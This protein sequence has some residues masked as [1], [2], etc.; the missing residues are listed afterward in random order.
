MLG[1][2][3]NLI[4]LNVLRTLD[5]IRFQRPQTKSRRRETNHLPLDIMYK[6]WFLFIDNATFNRIVCKVQN[7]RYKTNFAQD[8]RLKQWMRGKWM[9]ERL[10][11][12]NRINKI[13]EAITTATTT[14]SVAIIRQLE[15]CSLL[16]WKKNEE[17]K[18]M[19]NV[20]SAKLIEIH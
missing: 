4:R 15:M 20:C 1:I 13:T 2:K 3:W 5:E 7:Q 6:S 11:N 18:K 19:F 17:K 10:K 16:Q 8:I 14:I 9:D 12:P